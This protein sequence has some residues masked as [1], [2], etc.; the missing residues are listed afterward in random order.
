MENQPEPSVGLFR[1]RRV[2]LLASVA[3]CACTALGE[4][5]AATLAPARA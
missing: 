3:G 5:T 2:V 1:T 4:H